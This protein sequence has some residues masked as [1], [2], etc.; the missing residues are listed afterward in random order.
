MINLLRLF[1]RLLPVVFLLTVAT[2]R[3]EDKSITIG[4]NNWAENI[5]VAN[6]WKVLLDEK[7]VKVQ[8]QNADKALIYNS[9]AQG[10]ID[11]TFEVWL[12]SGDKPAFDKVK[13]RVVQI[14]PW[15]KEANLGLVVPDYVA[16]DSIDQLNANKTLFASAGRPKI[17]GIDSGSSLMQLTEK[18]KTAYQLDYDIQSSSESAMVLSLERAIQRKE[19]VVVTLWKPHW[20][21]SKYKLKYLKDPKGAY[22]ATDSI[23]GIETQAFR[24]QHPDVERWLQQWKMDDNSLGGLMSEIIRQG[25]STP[26]KGAKAWVDANRPLVQQWMK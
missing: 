8:L 3:A 18:A 15:F 10:K 19:P 11:L 9:V 6:M 14:G 20:I 1:T 17:V 4:V 13:D 26:E 23:Y 24:T 2:A 12:P 21:W 16:V 22:G 25:A 5:A 7:G